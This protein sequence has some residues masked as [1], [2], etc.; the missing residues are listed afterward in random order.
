MSDMWVC[1]THATFTPTVFRFIYF[2]SDTEN[3]PVTVPGLS[4]HPVTHAS[5]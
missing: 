4:T 3:L 2:C 5:Q 1:T